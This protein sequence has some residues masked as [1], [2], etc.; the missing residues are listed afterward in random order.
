MSRFLLL[1]AATLLFS[2]LPSS[3]HAQACGD[4]NGSGGF[5]TSDFVYMLNYIYNA[6]PSPTDFD[7]ADFDLHQ[8]WT[9]NDAQ[10][11]LNCLFGGCTNLS[12]FCPPTLGPIVPVAAEGFRIRHTAHFPAHIDH[13][14]IDLALDRPTTFGF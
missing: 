1:I 7:L 5:A 12:D 6:G 9:V 10:R 2:C 3:A 8:E 11:Q 14:V 13:A 4:A